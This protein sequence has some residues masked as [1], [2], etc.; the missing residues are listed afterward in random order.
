[1]TP[2]G[3]VESPINLFGLCEEAAVA[4]ENPYSMN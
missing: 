4:G 1:M 2:I 3:Y